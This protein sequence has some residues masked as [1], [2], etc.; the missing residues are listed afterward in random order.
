MQTQT[1]V[2]FLAISV[3]LSSCGLLDA[4]DRELP[5]INFPGHI[6]ESSLTEGDLNALSDKIVYR[7]K[8]LPNVI[9]V[10]NIDASRKG[11]VPLQ[12][13]QTFLKL[14]QR[15]PRSSF[16]VTQSSPE[17]ALPPRGR[18]HYED[19]EF[20]AATEAIAAS[21]VTLQ[22]VKVAIIDSGVVAKTPSVASALKWSTNF[23]LD[24]DKSRWQ[25]HASAIASIYAGVL[26]K[27]KIEDA[28]APNAQ[29]HS[30][31]IAFFGD[32]IDAV[33]PEY[34]ALQLAIA[35]DEA[36]ASG[37]RIVNLSFTYRDALPADVS[38]LEHAIISNAKNKGVVF[39]AASGN[40]GENIDSTKLLPARY[41]LENILVVGSHKRN[42]ERAQSS[43]FGDRVD[44][45]AQGVDVPVND[46]DGFFTFYSGTSFSAPMA[47]AAL[48]LYFGVKPE[49]TVKDALEDLF[50]T[51][52]S[53]YRGK[54]KG[55]RYGRID[56][57]A[58]VCRVL[59]S[60]SCE[61]KKV[62]K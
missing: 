20:Y 28:Y 55:S 19:G 35:L 40:S 48:A 32:A 57:K 29:L 10:K 23:T 53:S 16:S 5:L 7:F 39:V 42:F 49:A 37:A 31:K 61:I 2:S 18:G 12:N 54:T 41:D 33:K 45:T 15:F 34:G 9:Y 36:V 56:A 6:V 43:N 13:S 38:A 46:R 60:P 17:V 25:N 3:M 52:K 51:A 62:P 21:G 30:I 8:S 50:E 4:P 22:P 44:V 14:Q 24:A 47:G 58:F 26:R 59:V 27:G 1:R 11:F